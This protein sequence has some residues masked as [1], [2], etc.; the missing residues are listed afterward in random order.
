MVIRWRTSAV[1]LAAAAI[2]LS[3]ALGI[4]HGFGL[5][6]QPMS[7]EFGWGRE[8]FALAI[9]L[10]NLVWGAAQPVTGMIA[11]RFGAARTMVGGTVL[12]VAGLV[13]MSVSS[14]PGALFLSV[15]VLLGLG[16]S[17]TTF[18]VVLGAV[19][20]AVPPEQRSRAMGVATAIGSFGQFVMLPGSLS[21]IGWFGWSA[22]LI[23][24]AAIATSMAG[25]SAVLPWREHA[26]AAGSGVRA[27]DA[28]R[29][30]LAHNGFRLLAFGFFVCGFQVVFIITHL[31]AFL[32]DRGLSLSVG[33]NTL[34]L[35][36][37]ANVAGA[38]LAGVWGARYRKP[39]LLAAIYAG[40]AVV[41][42]AFV[43]APITEVSA[44]VFG[45]VI[46]L[47]WMSTVP[48]T[49]GT[50]AAV[51]GVRNM[52]ML[53][54][55]VFFVHQLGAFLGG[56]LGGYLYDRSGSYDGVWAIAIALSLLAAVVNLPIR[57]EP[58]RRLQPA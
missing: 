40:R 42:A 33:T 57:E 5:F 56:W 32:V 28:L 10:Q 15:G 30:A 3:I 26:A 34:A 35:I 52:A 8:T 6:L 48:L 14:T 24:L 11:D 45:I 4:R 49:N 22:A 13:L 43:L 19:S 27:G 16:L 2:V 9:A 21:L 20:R 7:L 41:I 36:G 53:S 37:L 47:L 44:Y 17:G 50:V 46:G 54:G 18:A 23:A 31:P 25:L 39:A 1:M 58:V 12:Y 51:F 29:A 38:Y 55:V